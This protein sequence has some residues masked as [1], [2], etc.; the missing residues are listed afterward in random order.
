MLKFVAPA[1][2]IVESGIMRWPRGI[3]LLVFI[4]YHGSKL[5]RGG[6]VSAARVSMQLY[7]SLC[8]KQLCVRGMHLQKVFFLTLAH[9]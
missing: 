9:Y 7:Y 5:Q 1:D 6:L 2:K 8:S 3:V 4:P